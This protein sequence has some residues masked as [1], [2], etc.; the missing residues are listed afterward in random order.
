MSSKRHA[1]AIA[2][3]ALVLSACGG[4]ELAGPSPPPP[5]PAPPPLPLPELYGDL[6]LRSISPEAGATVLARPCAQGSNRFCADQIELTIAVV[7]DRDL[8]G[9]VTVHF[10]GCGMA[11]SQVFSIAPHTPAVISLSRVDLSDDGPNHDG[12]GAALYCE[13][14]AVTQQMRVSLW[15]AGQPRNPLLTRDFARQ[16]TFVMR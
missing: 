2:L 1:R 7:V 8:E 15:Q 3:L 9:V 13:L 12:V 16:Y 14:P 4:R 10:G 11:S 6:T 5:S